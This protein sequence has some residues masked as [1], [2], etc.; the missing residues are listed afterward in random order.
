ME[1]CRFSKWATYTNLPAGTYTFRDCH[2]RRASG[3][4]GNGRPS[5]RDRR[6]V[7][8]VF[9]AL[10]GRS[11]QGPGRGGRDAH[12]QIQAPPEHHLLAGPGAAGVVIL[13]Y[14]R[15][16]V[17]D[18]R[19][20]RRRVFVYPARCPS[21]FRWSNFAEQPCGYDQFGVA[22]KNSLYVSIS[23]TLLAIAVGIRRP[24][25]WRAFPSGARASTASSCW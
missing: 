5:P 18:G 3:W 14:A 25:P 15:V 4:A 9:T 2:A 19:E 6:P 21:V 1:L 12:R 8:L 7:L 22:L 24:T 16:A 17:P 20:A 13:G 23:S 10:A 11:T